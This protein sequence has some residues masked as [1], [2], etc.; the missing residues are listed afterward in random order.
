MNLIR[1]LLLLQA[2]LV[3]ARVVELQVRQGPV[4]PIGTTS[5]STSPTSSSHSATGSS[6]QAAETTTSKRDDDDDD[7][8]D[9][10]TSPLLFFVALGF[11][12]VFT[13]LW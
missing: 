7:G 8:D 2:S 3:V 4:V 13:N 12:V 11:G 10:G 6:A 9:G 1:L 5:S